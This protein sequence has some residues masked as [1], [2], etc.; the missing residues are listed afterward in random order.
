MIRTG[1][2]QNNSQLLMEI[3]SL[4]ENSGQILSLDFKYVRKEIT[5]GVRGVH[6]AKRP[7]RASSPRK[8]RIIGPLCR[9]LWQDKQ[10]LNF[11]PSGEKK[12]KEYI[13]T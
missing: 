4:P 2:S 8:R 10:Q 12:K 3:F 7:T 13:K 9:R 1:L 6:R 5:D 11:P